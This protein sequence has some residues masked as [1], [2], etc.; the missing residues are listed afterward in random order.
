M[1]WISNL[2]LDLEQGIRSAAPAV[3]GNE[4]RLV[5]VGNCQAHPLTLGLMQA[6][7]QARIYATPSVHIATAE[8]V[9]HLHQRLND[10]DLL[11]MHRVQPGYRNDI[12]LDSVTLASLLPPSARSVVLP[13]LH[14]EGH[15]PWIGYAQDPDGRLSRL[16]EESPLGPYHDFLAMVAARDDLPLELL[17]DSA[18]P[19]AV[20]DQLRAHHH[21]SLAELAK[22]END[23]DLSISDWISN[24]HRRLPIAHTINHPTQATLDKLLRQLLQILGLPHELSEN[25]FDAAEHLGALRIPVHPWVRQALGL[26]AWA[27]SWGQRQGEPL[28]IEKQLEE[29]IA[30]YEQH[31]WILE[32]NTNHPKALLAGDLLTASDASSRLGA[33]KAHNHTIQPLSASD[34]IPYAFLNPLH[35]FPTDDQL[36]LRPAVNPL[37]W[38]FKLHTYRIGWREERDAIVLPVG[39][40]TKEG[41]LCDC[42]QYL[43]PQWSS[44]NWMSSMAGYNLCDEGGGLAL[45][46]KQGTPQQHLAGRWCVLND[47]VAHRNLGHF[48]HDLLPQMMAIRRLRQRWPNLQVLGSPERYPN[49]RILRELML[50]DAWQP[51]PPAQRLQVE[52]LTLQPLAFNGGIGFLAQPDDHWWLAVD[53]L[54]DGLQSLR[55]RLAPDPAALWRDH[56]VCFSRDLGVATEAPQGRFFSNYPQLIE[57]LSNAG[58]LIIDPGRHDIRQLQVL[59]AGAR[60]FVGIHGAG[61]F[62][63][64]LGQE[65]ARVVEIRPAC[66]C[67]RAL[68]LTC[69]AA[70]LDWRNVGC[71]TDPTDPERSIIPIDKVLALLD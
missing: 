62:N 20:L 33:Q 48:F 37:N 45:V 22:R 12:G 52:K 44:A 28:P 17:L 66:G 64:L 55:K 9:A 40:I 10:T 49:L 13:N 25:L 47:I 27:D 36:P 14:Y 6:L 70:G 39:V 5:V 1:P 19:V 8:D 69:K 15:H 29:S 32:V 4:I 3:E 42:L 26:D 38:D 71:E 65:S 34:P 7:P 18:C 58:V 60:G 57:Q 30:F 43:P 53:D 50:D 54:R 23:C 31:P 24:N 51:R 67:W 35:D 46:D 63:A 16:E 59:V 56:W 11:V 2:S 41:W 68:E 61:L 21:H